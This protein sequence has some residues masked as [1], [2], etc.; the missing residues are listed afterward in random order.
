MSVTAE[1]PV[2]TAVTAQT[3]EGVRVLTIDNPPVNA[4]S[5]VVSAALVREVEAADADAAVR[6]IVITGANGVFSGGADITEFSNPPPAGSKT[7]R[8]AIAA[9]EKSDK[10]FV[11]AIDGNALGGGCELAL[12]CDF[13]LATPG[14]RLGLPEILLGLIPGA[15]G[16]QRLPRLL[17]AKNPANG[18]MAG[19]QAAIEMMLK[20]EPKPAPQA[21]ALG[22]IDEIVDG[23]VVARA[24]VLAQE[25]AGTK[26]RVSA[27]TINVN[28]FM[29]AMAHK[30]VPA[31]EKGGFAAHKLIDAVEAASQL[32]F[33]H[34]LA[35]EARIFMELVV[36][37][38]SQAYRHIFFAEREITK[39]PGLA[40]DITPKAIKRAAIVGAGTMGTGI[41]MVFASAGIPVR[42]IDVNAEQ[43]ER[44]RKH[45][46][47]TYA[48]HVAKGRMSEEKAKGFVN[49]VEFVTDYAALADVDLVI[50]A[51]FESMKVKKEVFAAL[52]AAVN[53]EAILATNTSTLDIDEIAAATTRPE[54]VV[55]MHFFAP[56]NIMQL[57]EVVRGKASSDQTLVTV[58]A[59]S[60][61]LRKKGILSG[62]AFGFI[63]NSMLFPYAREANALVE[64]G[65][66]PWQVDRVIRDFGFPMGPFAMSDL[67]GIDVSYRISLEA[68]KVPYRTSELATRL[69]E[70]GRLGQKT[71]KG[72]FLYEPGNRKPVRD[73]EVEQIIAAESARLGITRREISD[74]EILQRCMFALVNQG[75]LLLGTG[76]ALRPGDEDIAWIY[77]YGFPAHTGGPMWWADTI[78]VRK[79]YDQIV[80]W[81]ETL[82]E[83]WE[84]APLLAEIAQANGTFAAYRPRVSAAR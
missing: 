46:A 45:V 5:S 16:T 19:L 47:D 61:T 73:P 76:I 2:R 4:L 7:I 74:E 83:Q 81:R 64:E 17:A 37:P 8:D 42:V 51:V 63:G 25:T 78:G 33:A 59:L 54:N 18:G 11:A 58:M 62:N 24:V 30:M 66:T 3:R 28:P 34:G 15:G 60:K 40:K 31:E 38:Q 48:G 39:I 44:G 43:V 53:R 20:G 75:A 41:A 56:A 84:P 50:E 14:S 12:A 29:V 6:A 57:L 32:D 49:A 35:R 52:D 72:F 23:D 13:R 1:T 22:L 79:I 67:S 71:G 68:P 27:T 77:G 55:G 80:T 65:A 26:H 69:Y 70:A 9:I 36:S 10:T 82:G 21:K